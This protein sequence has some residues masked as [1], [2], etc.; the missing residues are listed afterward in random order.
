MSKS[1]GVVPYLSVRDAK[2]AIAFYERAF[3][4]EVEE[5]A[6]ADDGRIMHCELEIEGGRVMLADV[7][8]EHGTHVAAPAADRPAAVGL[9]LSFKKGRAVDHAVADAVAAGAVVVTAP[10]NAFWGERFAEVRDP[11]GHIWHLA[12]PLKK[13]RDHD[14]EDDHQ[15]D[16]DD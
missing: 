2:A 1:R 10:H 8:P 5:I 13:R 15:D 11:F 3:D 14:D 9:R 12:G 6:K 16:H 4:A 7:F